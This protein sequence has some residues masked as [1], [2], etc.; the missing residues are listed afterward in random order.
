MVDET[1]NVC[2]FGV[3]HSKPGFAPTLPVLPEHDAKYVTLG[4]LATTLPLSVSGPAPRAFLA[5]TT[6]R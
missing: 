1:A 6:H 3:D 4:R 5:L 2:T